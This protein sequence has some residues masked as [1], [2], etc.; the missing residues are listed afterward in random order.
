M[1]SESLD[2]A[3]HRLVEKLSSLSGSP[4]FADIANSRGEVLGRYGPLFS[5]RAS[6][7]LVP[8]ISAAS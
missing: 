2:L 4:E 6:L 7:A 5:P 3:V 1:D 8:K